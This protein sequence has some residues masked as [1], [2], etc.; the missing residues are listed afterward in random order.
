MITGKIPKSCIAETILIKFRC[1]LSD[2]CCFTVWAKNKKDCLYICGWYCAVHCGHSNEGLIIECYKEM[3]TLWR[4]T[5]I[6]VLVV[7]QLR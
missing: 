1:L 6:A 4:L 7:H 5:S 3:A 2:G